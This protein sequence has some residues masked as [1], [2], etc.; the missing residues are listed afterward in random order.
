[1]N[2][3][4]IDPPPHH[5]HPSILNLLFYVSG[6]SNNEYKNKKISL[7][8]SKQ[9]NGFA[10]KNMQMFVKLFEYFIWIGV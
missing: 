9:L 2:K 10:E 4:L 1:M 5:H 8:N 3:H 6:Q 7:K